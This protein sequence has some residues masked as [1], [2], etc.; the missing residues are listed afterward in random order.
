MSMDT[1]ADDLIKALQFMEEYDIT[2]DEAKW[3]LDHDPYSGMNVPIKI[4]HTKILGLMIDYLERQGYKLWAKGCGMAFMMRVKNANVEKI[5]ICRRVFDGCSS[6][7]KGVSHQVGCSKH[8]AETDHGPGTDEAESETPS[9]EEKGHGTLIGICVGLGMAL[10][11]LLL[12]EL[13]QIDVGLWLIQ[14][15]LLV[16]LFSVLHWTR[17]AHY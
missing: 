10:L 11:G 7:T 1:R 17:T 4:V 14:I 2:Q 3:A 9:D 6:D 15:G 13:G 16:F 5:F 8:Q 12:M